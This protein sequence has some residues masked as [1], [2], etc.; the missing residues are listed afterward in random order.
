M[1]PFGI[2]WKKNLEEKA[3]FASQSLNTISHENWY[4]TGTLICGRCILSRNMV[5]G[6][7]Q[8]QPFVSYSI[9]TF[10]FTPLVEPVEDGLGRPISLCWLG[11]GYFGEAKLQLLQ[12]VRSSRP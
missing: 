12:C 2:A 5:S 9:D 8:N 4:T 11:S 6:Q 7:L 3:T 10:Q 1:T